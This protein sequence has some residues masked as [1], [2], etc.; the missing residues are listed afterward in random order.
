MEQT[1]IVTALKEEIQ[2]EAEK[3]KRLAAYYAEHF[4]GCAAMLSRERYEACDEYLTLRDWTMQRAEK[5]QR[6]FT[7]TF[8]RKRNSLLARSLFFTAEAAYEAMRIIR[9][10]QSDCTPEL[11]ARLEMLLVKA[12][13]DCSHQRKMLNWLVDGGNKSLNEDENWQ[14][15]IKKYYVP[16]SSV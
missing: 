6:V 10:I 15:F 4:P 1:A 2:K 16:F 12:R 13:A 11:H 7:F 5:Q 9:V 14:V 3:V 8:E